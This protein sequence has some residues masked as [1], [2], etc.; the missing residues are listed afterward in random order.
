MVIDLVLIGLAM[1]FYPIALTI[2][3]LLLASRHGPRKG[4]GFIFGWLVALAVV[5]AATIL[6]TGDEPPASGTA[7]ST[8]ILAVK[9][10]LGLVL[11][12]IAERQRR[13]IGQPRQRERGAQVASAH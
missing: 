8:G 10:V 7:P 11:L 4:A 2:F 12:A 6:A 1:A 3:I 13:R 9:I 5:A